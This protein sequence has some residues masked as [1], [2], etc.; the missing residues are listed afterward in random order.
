MRPKTKEKQKQ[1]ELFE[2]EL[3]R[4]V[5][6][7]HALVRLGRQMNWEAF[8]GQLGSTY[9]PRKGAP[10]VGTRLM[11]ALHYL[12]YQYDLSDE[13][14]ISQWVEN[15]YWRHF[16]G[17]QFFQREAPVDA[18]SMTRWRARLGKSG[19]ELMLRQTIETGIKIK[20][21]KPAQLKRVNMDTTVQT[22]AI[23][24]PTGAR[25]HNRARERM[26]GEAHKS[27]KRIKQSYARTGP[28]LLM[29]QSRYAHARQMKRAAGCARKLR[30]NLGRVIR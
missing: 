29:Q 6:P 4:L 25:L 27:G 14:V 10:G 15:A 12:K 9:H 18:S 2:V 23:R 19:A 1:M 5:N 13:S 28:R 24:Y 22:K 3:E 21:I 20:A 11:V 26:V 30:T 16:S 17:E 7:E 8:E